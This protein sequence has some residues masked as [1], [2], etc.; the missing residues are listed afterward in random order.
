MVELTRLE[1][2]MLRQVSEPQQSTEQLVWEV[3]LQNVGQMVAQFTEYLMG[4]SLLN[5]YTTKYS[6]ISKHIQSLQ[7][8]IA[9]VANVNTHIHKRTDAFSYLTESGKRRAEGGIGIHE[10]TVACSGVTSETST[11]Q[12]LKITQEPNQPFRTHSKCLMLKPKCCCHSPLKCLSCLE[13][14]TRSV[15]LSQ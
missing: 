1:I 4:S 3:L 15:T 11:K 12:L 2:V 13:L 8:K 6:H 7:Y 10:Q 14:Q 9:L 5:L